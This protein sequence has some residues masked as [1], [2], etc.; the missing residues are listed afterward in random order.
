[1]GVGIAVLPI[2]PITATFK[3]CVH[4]ILKEVKKQLV[5]HQ[6]KIFVRSGRPNYQEGL[7]VMRLLGECLDVP[8]RLR[9]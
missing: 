3:D 9:L 7:K 1:M 8:I 2:S 4:H 5:T 6:V